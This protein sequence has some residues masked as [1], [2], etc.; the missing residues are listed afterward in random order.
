MLYNFLDMGLNTSIPPMD[1][2]SAV[3]KKF[4]KLGVVN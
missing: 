1:F 3:K 2:S 4:K